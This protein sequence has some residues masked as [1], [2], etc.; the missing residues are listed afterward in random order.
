MTTIWVSA[1]AAQ[2]RLSLDE[3]EIVL[4]GCPDELWEASMWEVSAD[5]GP[6]TDPDGRPFDDPAVSER[7]LRAQGAVWRTAYHALFFT[8]AD[9]SAMETDWAP[10][11]PF[12]PHDEDWYV[13]PPTYSREQL[14][15]YVDHC[16]RQA[17][18]LFADLTDDQGAA[19]LPR[20]HLG[21][22][23]DSLARQLVLGVYHLPL[24][25]AQVRTFLRSQGV[26]CADD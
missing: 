21:A 18:K 15:G 25:S 12:S 8:D 26:R 17:D 1:V 2:Y 7:K 13:V 23:T 11:A 5:G 19:Q 3:M 20:W 16:R 4:R 9:L 10:P 14:L 6:V 24:H 22:G